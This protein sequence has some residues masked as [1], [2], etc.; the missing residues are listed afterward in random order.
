MI[1]TFNQKRSAQNCG[2]KINQAK[3]TRNI[4]AQSLTIGKYNIESVKYFILLGSDNI[5]D[6]EVKR[7]IFMPVK[8]IIVILNH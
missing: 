6:E 4:Q 2:L 5:V 8:V 3:T 7:Q 1:E